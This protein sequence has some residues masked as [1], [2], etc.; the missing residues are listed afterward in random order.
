MDLFFLDDLAVDLDFSNSDDRATF[1]GLVAR[2]LETTKLT[3]INGWL[4]TSFRTRRKAIRAVADCYMP[5][6][7]DL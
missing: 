6:A 3:A 1:R 2:R 5:F 7:Y 4:G